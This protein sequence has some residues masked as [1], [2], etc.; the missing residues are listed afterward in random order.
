MVIGSG[1]IVIGQAAEFDYAGTQACLALKEE[2]YEVILV[3]SNPATIMTDTDFGTAQ[4]IIDDRKV[5][6]RRKPV[7]AVKSRLKSYSLKGL[8]SL[9]KH[10]TRLPVQLKERGAKRIFAFAT[11]GLFTDGFDK[12]DK[13]HKDGVLTKVFTTNLI[14]REPALL[15]RPWYQ[16]VNMSKYIAHIVNVLNHD[17]SISSLLSPV[18][19]IHQLMERH[20]QD[21]QAKEN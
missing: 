21:L 12:F 1:P 2:G 11:F 19:R 16:E 20:E 6:D 7:F 8:T 17:M 4:F 15:E 5:K 3:N 9:Y 18:Q 14:Y 13:A 10:Q